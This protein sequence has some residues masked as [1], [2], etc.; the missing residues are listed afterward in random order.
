MFEKILRRTYFKT[1]PLDETNRAFTEE[2]PTS[3][4][5]TFSISLLFTGS[6]I[7]FLCLENL[8]TA[9]TEPHKW[10][11]TGYLCVRHLENLHTSSNSPRDPW[12]YEKPCLPK[13]NR[14]DHRFMSLTFLTVSS[15]QNLY[16]LSQALAENHKAHLW[17]ATI[18][19]AFLL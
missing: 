12:A 14:H 10:Q 7:L 6:K 1:S 9:L 11:P 19:R 3:I 16:V 2:V 5:I 8:K 17:H 15:C 13:G 18:L 4:P